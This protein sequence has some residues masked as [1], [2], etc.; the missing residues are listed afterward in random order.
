MKQFLTSIQSIGFVVLV[1]LISS[2]TGLKDVSEDRPI[3]D[4]FEL[5]WENDNPEED[6]AEVRYELE[7]VVL[8]EPVNQI[9]WMRPGIAIHQAVKEPEKEKGFK[10]WLKYQIGAEPVYMEDVPLS[11][12]A[13]AME[14]RLFNRGYYNAEVSYQVKRKG[15]TATAEFTANPGKPHRIRKI[16]YQKNRSELYWLMAN[17]RDKSLL[18]STDLYDLS[19]IKEE[20]ERLST[21]L[22][23]DGYYHFSP[24]FLLFSADTTISNRRVD[25]TLWRKPRIP[26]KSFNR[27]QIRNIYVHADYKDVDYDPDTTRV[28]SVYFL[29]NENIFKPRHILN[30]VAIEPGDYY[31]QTEVNNT[32]S[33]LMSYGIYRYNNADFKVVNDSLID[34]K[35][36]LRTQKRKS[37]YSELSATSKSNNF[38]GPG[39]RL[40][41]QDRNL[42]GGAEVLDVSINASY[43]KQ[44]AGAGKGTEAYELKTEARL[45]LPRLV[46]FEIEGLSK[47]YTPKTSFNIGGGV[48]RRL[49]LYQLV[50]ANTGIE[51]SYRPHKLLMHQFGFLQLSLS[52]LSNTSRQFQDFLDVNPSV[53]RSFEEQFIPSMS[54]TLSYNSEKKGEFKPSYFA[55]L[56]L[57][58]AGNIPYALGEV[59]QPDQEPRKLFGLKYA[60]FFRVMP[61]FVY[62]FPLGTRDHKMV[63]RARPQIAI[64]YGNSDVVPYIRQ[65]FVGGTQSL[66]A[67]PVRS[68]GPGTYNPPDSLSRF[69]VDQTGD[70]LLEANLEY[71]FPI[72]G[73]IKGALFLDA[74]NVWLLNEDP[75]RP[76][77]QISDEFYRELGIG[78]GFGLRIDIE[79]LVLRFDLAFP[80]RDPGL[81]QNERWVADEINP[82]DGG[83]RT[84][85]L[86]LNF[87]IGYPF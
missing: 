82:L 72:E 66:R 6:E 26:K 74:G 17:S 22:R 34:A 87:A 80:L 54:Y 83:W 9:L 37:V 57:E 39:I 2:C 85:N 24:D 21:V 25:L 67:F 8:P 86:I 43:E 41:Y 3:F 59:I 56:G 50:S 27:Y 15:K 4:G 68:V 5:N 84:D 14:N 49:R 71:R 16:D 70:V 62:N 10:Y 38:A 28:D 29:N 47:R 61:E 1:L 20:R 30:G 23:D 73:F 69:L 60:Q 51:Y 53:E 76:G 13:R 65:F 77:S 48:Y 11:D 42:F 40:G 36:F 7:D 19:N 75:Q 32:L 78:T 44:I 63:F 12:I 35:I 81:P 33:T 79:F 52:D 31:S 55:R 58:A 18:D 46:P 64:P 45:D